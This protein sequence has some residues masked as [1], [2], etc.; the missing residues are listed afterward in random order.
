MS[1]SMLA[2]VVAAFAAIAPAAAL[3]Q[4]GQ[5]PTLTFD[6]PCYSPG[7]QMA[8]SGSGYTPGGPIQMLFTSFSTQVNGS[9]DTAA[10]AA[11]AISGT[12]DTPDPDL[13]LGDAEFSGT[14]GVSANDRTRIDAGAPPDQQFAGSTFTLSRFEVQ[15]DQPNGRAPKA[16]K[17]MR[18]IAVG[19]TNARGR[20]LYVHYRRGAR[21]VKTIQLGR[22]RG[23]CGDRSRTLPRA[24]PRG[25][26][27]GRY[28]LVF[29][30]SAR[31]VRSF[32]RWTESVRL[33]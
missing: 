13:F 4:G 30:T 5:S 7:D 27:P 9:Y 8:Y 32:P 11:G 2:A 18:V 6:Q 22:L 23:D 28:Q 24:L 17:P 33:G 10:D 25:A 31:S 14:M 26:H 1:R 21:V 16:R 15:V 19:F 3:A 20:V 12:I 29:N